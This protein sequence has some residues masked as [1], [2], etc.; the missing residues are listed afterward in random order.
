MMEILKEVMSLLR[1]DEWVERKR[2]VSSNSSVSP[3]SFVS[4]N[5]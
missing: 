4:R 5:R 3:L 2:T 1:G